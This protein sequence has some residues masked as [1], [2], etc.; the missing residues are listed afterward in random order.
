MSIKL[1][2]R[3]L[4]VHLIVEP[5]AVEQVT[6]WGVVVPEIAQAKSVRGKVLAVGP[7]QVSAQGVRLPMEVT[8][9][10]WV[11]FAKYAGTELDVD[12]DGALILREADVL[13]IIEPDEGEAG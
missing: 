13:A 12:G 4:R 6:A 7:G 5:A 8:E 10:D 11:L 9:G 3:P 2:F 1:N